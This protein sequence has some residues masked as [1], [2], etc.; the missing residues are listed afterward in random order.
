MIPR[1]ARTPKCAVKRVH[2]SFKFLR[3]PESFAKNPKKEK[4][5]KAPNI[6]KGRKIR[7]LYWRYE[8]VGL[9]YP[10]KCLK[11]GKDKGKG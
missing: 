4:S 9:Y 5:N 10:W 1:I 6:E 8:G 7:S 11:S 3:M 2:E